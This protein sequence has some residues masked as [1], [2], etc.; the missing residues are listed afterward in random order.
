MEIVSLVRPEGVWR[1][2]DG[3]EADRYGAGW[4]RTAKI[5]VLN[6]SVPDSTEIIGTIQI[7]SGPYTVPHMAMGQ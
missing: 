3:I 5:L 6:P 2:C 1:C 4:S 7:S